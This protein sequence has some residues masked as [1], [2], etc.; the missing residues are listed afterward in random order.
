MGKTVYLE[1][2]HYFFAPLFFAILYMVVVLHNRDFYSR[3]FI[4]SMLLYSGISLYF[5][6]ITSV[7]ETYL[8][9]NICELYFLK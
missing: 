1:T 6:V 5:S 9:F 3:P 2:I 4:P 8:P 7:S